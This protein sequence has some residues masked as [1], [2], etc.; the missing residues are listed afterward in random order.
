VDV[1]RFGLGLRALRRQRGLTQAQLASRVG[2]SGSAVSRLERGEADRV[3]LRSLERVSGALGARIDLRLLW[4]GEGLDRLMDQGHAALVEDIVGLLRGLGWS[5]ATEVSFNIQGERGS[6]DVLAYHP[7]HSVLLVVEAK[8]V[9]PDLQ[10]MLVTLD[11]KSRLAHAIGA[12]REWRAGAVGRLL[13][14]PADR[15]ARRR[16]ARHHA[17]FASVL[18]ARTVE[19]RRWLRRPS[20]SL[21]G[22][23]FLSSGRHTQARH[24]VRRAARSR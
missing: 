14:L 15:T 3:A 12:E 9:V 11:R 23:L 21:N 2:M 7:G 16:V 4:H 19:V 5:V 20:G 24:R 8:S 18:P 10:S 17:T 22:I 6:I 13:V 1:V